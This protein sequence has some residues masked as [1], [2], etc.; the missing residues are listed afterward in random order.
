[1]FYRSTHG[2]FLDDENQGKDVDDLD[3][4]SL[5][6]IGQQWQS[7]LEK[8]GPTSESTSEE[9]PTQSAAKEVDPTSQ[10]EA[11][12]E[13]IGGEEADEEAIGDEEE[14]GAQSE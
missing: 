4:D 11:D 2:D 3:F 10:E 8:R 1:M 6:E 14:D 9:A 5:N 7:A 12:E 13:V